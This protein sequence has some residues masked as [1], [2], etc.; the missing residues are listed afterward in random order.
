MVVNAAG[1][2][3]L[4]NDSE[5]LRQALGQCVSVGEVMFRV[6]GVYKKNDCEFEDGS[7]QGIIPAGVFAHYFHQEEKPHL[8]TLSMAE[9]A[10]V[11]SL[12]K[13]VIKLLNSQGSLNLVAEYSFDNSAKWIDEGENQFNIVTFV[14]TGLGAISLVVAAIGIMNMMFIAVAERTF[15]IGIRRAMGAKKREIRQQFLLE[16][17]LVTLIGGAI[18]YLLGVGLANL[19]GSVIEFPISLHLSVVLLAIGISA[20][21]GISASF[22]PALKASNKDLIQILR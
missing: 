10:T 9:G 3:K 15:E 17:C 21:V 19:F 4:S 8:L 5:D 22:L 14:L 16:G 12:Q 18:G 2:K 11:A 7:L 13:S 1:A 20:L 6:V